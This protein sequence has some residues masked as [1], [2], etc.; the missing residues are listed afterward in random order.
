LIE[1]DKVEVAASEERAVVIALNKPE[2]YTTTVKDEHA[3]KTVMELLDLPGRRVYPVG[4]LDKDSRGLLLFTDDG[5]LAFKLTHPSHGIDKTYRVGAWGGLTPEDL[6]KMAAGVDLEEGRTLPAKL[7]NIRIDGKKARFTITIRE[8]KKR[9]IRR[10]V[11]AVGG[12]VSDL[13]RVSFAG[14]ELGDIPEGK[15]RFLT[16]KEVAN[17]KKLAEASISNKKPKP[18]KLKPSP[19]A[20]F[21]AGGQRAAPK[22]AVKREP[23]PKT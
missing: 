13:C 14:I 12:N 3:E 7:E 19:N 6:K 16:K 15:W 4:R 1:V 21:S 18:R 11:R 23:R 8:G 22:K 17:L 2:G 20:D 9:Q 10:M 5:D